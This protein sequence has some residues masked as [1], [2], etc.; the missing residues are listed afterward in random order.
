MNKLN[1]TLI[2]LV[3]FSTIASAAILSEYIK[4]ERTIE[5]AP[6]MSFEINN[7]PR[8]ITFGDALLH[9]Y[10]NVTSNKEYATTCEIET[11]IY[12]NDEELLDL[13]GIYIDYSTETGTGSLSL[14][15]DLNENG[16][17]EVAIK[18]TQDT[19]THYTIRRN[20]LMNEDVVPGSYRIVTRL[21]P[22]QGNS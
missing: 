13:E 9:D 8:N 21:I 4:T 22:Y 15:T 1:K 19:D 12:F 5:V 6:W 17:P 7:D 16:F 10:I 14:A 18:G 20:T 11:V 2:V 3:L